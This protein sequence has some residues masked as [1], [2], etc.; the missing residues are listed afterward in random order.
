MLGQ[1]DY[2]SYAQVM[3]QTCGKTFRPNNSDMQDTVSHSDTDVRH[4]TT[5]VGTVSM[6][7]DAVNAS[8]RTNNGWL[9][10][11]DTVMGK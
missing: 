1:H 6:C 11:K 7:A 3:S 5:S 2:K 4:K 10:S 9:H 8:D